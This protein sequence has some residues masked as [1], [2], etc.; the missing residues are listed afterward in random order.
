VTVLQLFYQEEEL[1]AEDIVCMGSVWKV[2]LILVVA[3]ELHFHACT[4]ACVDYLQSV[5]WNDQELEDIVAPHPAGGS[6]LPAGFCAVRVGHSSCHNALEASKL[7][8]RC[9]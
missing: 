1:I 7:R 6:G 5:P 9:C 2:L 4:T 3:A 8:E